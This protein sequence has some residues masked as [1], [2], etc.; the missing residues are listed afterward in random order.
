M[1]VTIE[2]TNGTVVASV[3]GSIDALTAPDL[4]QALDERIA[5]GHV[6]MVVDLRG[7]EY[8]SSAGL[9]T[10]LRSL[11]RA[12]RDGGDLRLADL[13]PSVLHVLELSGFT[14]ILQ[15]FETTSDAVASFGGQ[16]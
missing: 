13:Q 15:S 11:K 7:V 16:Q 8:I 10:I 3:R 12:R 9:R 5:A 1:T 2:Q 6:Q 4:S 14:S